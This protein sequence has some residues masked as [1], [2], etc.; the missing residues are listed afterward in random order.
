M[1]IALV[2]VVGSKTQGDPLSAA[3]VG[4]VSEVGCYR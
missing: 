1:V 2:V 4:S 3:G